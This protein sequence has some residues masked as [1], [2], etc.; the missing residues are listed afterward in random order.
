MNINEIMTASPAGLPT[1]NLADVAKIMVQKNCGA[2]PV[3]DNLSSMKPVGMITDRDITLRT[4]ANGHNPLELAAKDVM[5]IN[6]VSVSPQT[7]VEDCCALMEKHAIRRMLVTDESGK[8]VGIV[9]Q[10]DIAQM[11]P[12]DEVAELVRDISKASYAAAGII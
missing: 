10:A 4:L 3:V 6:P 12:E 2:V 1:T 9:A 8:C 5:T 7:S 11:A